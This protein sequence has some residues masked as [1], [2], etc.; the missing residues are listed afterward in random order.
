MT[1]KPETDDRPAAVKL[2]D[3]NISTLTLA[4]AATVLGVAKST[5]NDAA[6]TTG[7]VADGVPVLRVGRRYL[8]PA[9]PLRERLGVFCVGDPRAEWF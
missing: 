5:V 9:A 2:R 8:V 4:E 1:T 6:R 3:P 7:Q